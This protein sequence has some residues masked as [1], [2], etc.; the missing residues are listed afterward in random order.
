M[1]TKNKHFY[2]VQAV[3]SAL[4]V[5]FKHVGRA[6]YI[7]FSFSARSNCIDHRKLHLVRV[8][9]GIPLASGKLSATLWT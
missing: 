1:V 3:L 7:C 6:S 8:E 5:Y 2:I 9:K 4:I